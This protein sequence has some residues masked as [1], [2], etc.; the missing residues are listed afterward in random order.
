MVK[1]PGTG[2]R[3]TSGMVSRDGSSPERA[4]TLS[5]TPAVAAQQ[6]SKLPDGT[7]IIDPRTKQPAQIKRRQ[8]GGSPL[9]ETAAPAAPTPTGPADFYGSTM[10][11]LNT[12]DISNRLNPA[13]PA[14]PTALE[15]AL[16][17]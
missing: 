13:G 4:I 10:P 11:R 6:A 9:P 16:G 3:A 5:T 2:G 17:G 12:Q 7:W 8:P 15:Q 1:L 14:A